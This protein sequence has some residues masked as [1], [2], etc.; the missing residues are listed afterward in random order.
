MLGI[1]FV[2]LWLAFLY[3]LWR[4]WVWKFRREPCGYCGEMMRR[5]SLSC[6]HC[7]K[8]LM[9]AFDL[10]DNVPGRRPPSEEDGGG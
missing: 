10:L 8:S 3:A 7:G 6:P 2:V 4:L 5:G 9:S 1:L